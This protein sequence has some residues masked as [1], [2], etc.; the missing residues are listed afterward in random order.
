MIWKRDQQS[1]LSVYAGAPDDRVADAVVRHCFRLRNK[2]GRNSLR[3]CSHEN[4]LTYKCS[5]SSPQKC[6]KQR[7]VCRIF[8]LSIAEVIGVGPD[9]TLIDQARPHRTQTYFSL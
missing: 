5:L 1:P 4:T 9:R 2:T 3:V 7:L 8:L 6:H